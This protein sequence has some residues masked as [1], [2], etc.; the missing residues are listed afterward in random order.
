MKTI[1][2][3]FF[4]LLGV[5]VILVVYQESRDE[6][7]YA[8]IRFQAEF[9]QLADISELSSLARKTREFVIWEKIRDTARAVSEDETALKIM[10]NDLDE[11]NR[12]PQ[13]IAL[14]TETRERAQQNKNK[15]VSLLGLASKF[16]QFENGDQ[17]STY[18]FLGRIITDDLLMNERKWYDV[19]KQVEDLQPH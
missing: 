17:T 11:I 2:A 16:G 18:G 10:L 8:R 9:G 14:A 13:K 3:V 1:A 6:Y 15:L 7:D 4:M 12:D 5:G 19:L